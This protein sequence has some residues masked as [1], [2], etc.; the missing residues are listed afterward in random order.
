MTPSDIAAPIAPRRAVSGS[1]ARLDESSWQSAVPARRPTISQPIGGLRHMRKRSDQYDYVIAVVGAA[2]C[3]KT[4]LIKTG[5]GSC[6]LV[7]CP[8]LLTLG[9]AGLEGRM[10]FVWSS[11]AGASRVVEDAL[12]VMQI[13]A[14]LRSA[15]VLVVETSLLD[16]DTLSAWPV[17]LPRMDGVVLCYDAT[18]ASSFD[19]VPTL[20]Q[21]CHDL[22]LSTVLVACKTDLPRPE[23][24]DARSA[25]ERAGAYQ[26]GL[27]EVGTSGDGKRKMRDTFGWL[28]RD[29]A[30]S[31]ALPFADYR[32]LTSELQMAL[33]PSKFGGLSDVYGAEWRSPNGRVKVAIK[34]LRQH[35]RNQMKML[36]RLRREI[37]VWQQL[38]HPNVLPLYGVHLGM[39]AFPSLVSPWS[40]NGDICSYLASRRDASDPLDLKMHLLEQV[41]NG[42]QY[43]HSHV[44]V[45]VH[46]DIKGANILVS[47][48]HVVQL[49]DF[50]FASMQAHYDFSNAH[51]SSVKG[52]WRW[53]APELVTDDN[54]SY[55]T[56]S[57]IWA[58]GC[59]VVEVLGERLPFHEKRNDQSVIMA[60]FKGEHPSRPAKVPDGVWALLLDCW[61]VDPGLRPA[62][63]V[64][65]ERMRDVRHQLG[66]F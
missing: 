19:A 50:G 64:V 57:D 39:G 11:S 36:Q 17:G 32:D 30:R 20:L 60:I 66:H 45:I 6:G 38:Q 31:R 18:D 24:V 40:E 21:D 35:S 33:R 14:S 44:P 61:E 34:V 54:A 48:A 56:H 1:Y 51:S 2:G 22:C 53:M 7:E 12:Q 49:C 46:G 4:T 15:R 10:D 16:K 52:S 62:V 47:D 23:A 5:L 63:D 28:M 42:L 29:I 27:I 8:M 59:V 58:Y 26:I 25:S 37:Y 3:G 9:P 65:L 41:L 43:L 13:D 55:T